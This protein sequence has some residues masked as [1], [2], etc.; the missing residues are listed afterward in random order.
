MGLLIERIWPGNRWRNYHYLVACPRT[1]E[2]LAID[3]LDWEQCLRHAQ[4]RG[5]TLVGIFNTHEHSD[6]IGGNEALRAATGAPVIAHAGAVGRI[7]GIDRLVQAGDLIQIGETG[8]LRVLDTPGHTFAHACLLSEESQPKLFCGDTLFSAGAGNCHNGGDPAILYETFSRQLAPLKDDTLVYPGHDYM[9]RNL[10]FTLDREP[11]NQRARR[12][13]QAVASLEGL[14]TPVT[15]LGEEREFNT[16]FRL[17]SEEI[18]TGL[19][20]RLPQLPP[21]PQERDVFMA[22]RQLRNDW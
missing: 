4:Q 12:Q 1:G 6:H 14:T 9:A 8:R 17:N 19:R 11:G 16:F 20:A 15:T 21:Q 22:L 7:P 10:A 18:M 5:W 3:P 2:A 13:W